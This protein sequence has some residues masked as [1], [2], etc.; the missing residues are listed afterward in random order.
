L[1]LQT[2]KKSVPIIISGSTEPDV[3]HRS[4][5]IEKATNL[6]GFKPTITL[7]DGIARFMEVY[8]SIQAIKK[9][10]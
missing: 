10:A 7:A 1:M 9:A 3:L 5:N 4:P 6:L 2:R 8:E